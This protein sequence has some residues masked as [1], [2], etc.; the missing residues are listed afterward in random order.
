MGCECRR[1]RPIRRGQAPAVGLLSSCHGP[2]E[3]IPPPPG[4]TGPGSREAGP[5]KSPTRPPQQSNQQQISAHF[6]GA[7]PPHPPPPPTRR[8]ANSALIWPPMKS[9]AIIAGQLAGQGTG[10]PGY[11]IGGII[12][13]R[14][15]SPV[16]SLA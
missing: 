11:L 10:V 16:K 3:P 14:R 5:H 15:F 4:T 9:A 1:G 7:P 2:R 12:A 8:A 13:E 6:P